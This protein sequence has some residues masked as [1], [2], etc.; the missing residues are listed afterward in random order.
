[1]GRGKA[2]DRQ[3]PGGHMGRG[4]ATDWQGQA[5][6]RQRTSDEEAMRSLAEGWPKIN[7]DRRHTG[8]AA[9]YTLFAS[10]RVLIYHKK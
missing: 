4:L 6:D 1:M 8:H 5:T 10:M 3:T 2:T 9:S 7:S